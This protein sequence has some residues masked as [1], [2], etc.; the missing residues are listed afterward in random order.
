MESFGRWM[1]YLRPPRREEL[2]LERDRERTPAVVF[3]RPFPTV[4]PA[5]DF[6]VLPAF[7]ETG[8]PALAALRAPREA[9][10]FRPEV[11]LDPAVFRE[12][13][14]AV[15]AGVRFEVLFLEVLFLEEERP[16]LDVFALDLLAADFPTPPRAEALPAAV[17]PR[18][19]AGAVLA[20]GLVTDGRVEVEAARLPA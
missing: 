3:A 17:V 4:R 16:D 20:I 6:L 5:A 18:P 13:R 19:G 2:R 1:P 7:R 8:F 10:V 11:F 15:A 12:A 9:V 14:P